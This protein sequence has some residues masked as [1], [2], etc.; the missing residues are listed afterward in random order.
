MIKVSLFNKQLSIFK[1]A[2]RSRKFSCVFIIF[3]KKTV[4]EFVL[5]YLNQES[6]KT[7]ISCKMKHIFIASNNLKFSKKNIIF[8]LSNEKDHILSFDLMLDLQNPMADRRDNCIQS[9]YVSIWA[10]LFFLFYN[11]G[12]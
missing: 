4:F 5:S 10:I 2:K 12:K 11:I 6:N 7:S 9:G 3:C 1:Y 8:S